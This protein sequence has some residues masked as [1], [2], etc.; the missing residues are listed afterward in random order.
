VVSVCI[1]SA[2]HGRPAVTE[3]VL[4]QRALLV[5]GLVEGGR[6][7]VSL[8]Y[9]EDENLDV[10][11]SLGHEAVHHPNRPLGAKC[12]AGLRHA[13]QLADFVV[14]IGSDDWIHPDVFDSLPDELDDQGEIHHGNRLAMVDLAEGTLT[15]ISSPSQYGA[16]PW[17]IDS[18]LL[19][20]GRHALIQPHLDRGL[21]G[22]LIR[23]MRLNRRLPMRFVK[24]DPHE[25]R[26]VDF[27]TGENITP[28]RGVTAHLGIAPEE[29][30]WP[31][32]LERYPAELVDEARALSDNFRE[33]GLRPATPKRRPRLMAPDGST[34]VAT[35]AGAEVL[36]RR[37]Y[38]D[39]E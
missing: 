1:F 11:R 5:A 27:K 19:L 36:R 14:W 15:R 13:A 28:Y 26:C 23:G 4:R 3:L 30:A 9:A 32:L 31:A 12:S 6:Q 7:A 25:F 22:A 29:A 24:H 16:I 35:A 37:G 20:D 10:A 21:D 39:V 38:V 34:V 17:I 8:I 33:A 2:A 18:R